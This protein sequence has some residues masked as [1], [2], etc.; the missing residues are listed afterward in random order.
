[1]TIMTTA[2]LIDNERYQD[3]PRA[4][5]LRTRLHEIMAHDRVDHRLAHAFPK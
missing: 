1:M 3:H 4:F 2:Y 5:T